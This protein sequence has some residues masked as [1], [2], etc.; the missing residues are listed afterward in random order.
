MSILP[1]HAHRTFAADERSVAK[2]RAFAREMLEAWDAGDLADSVVLLVSELVTNAV[3]HAGTTARLELRLDPQS[4]RVEVEDLHPRRVLPMVVAEP[5]E[6][7]EEGRGLLIT[8]SLASAWGVDYTSASKRVWLRFDR[9]VDQLSVPRWSPRPGDPRGHAHVAVAELSGDGVVTA[10]NDDAVA[11]F[12]WS[13]DEVRGR[14]FDELLDRVPGDHTTEAPSTAKMASGWQGTYCVLHKDADPVLVFASHVGRER[15]RGSTALMVATDQRVLIERPPV[16]PGQPPADPGILGLMDEALVRLR[17]DDYLMLAVERVRDRLSADAAYLLMLRDLEDEYEVKAVSGLSASMLGTR[18]ASNAA[19]T[20]D[21]R[22]PHLPVVVGDLAQTSVPLLAGTGLR[23]LVL[24]PISAESRVVGAIGVGSAHVEGFSTDQSV[25]L[26]QIANALAVATDRARLQSLER[27]R[28]G[29]LTFLAEA[30]DFLAGSLDQEMTMAITG[31]IVVPKIAQWCAVH[32]DDDRGHPVLEQVWHED[33][34]QTEPL[35][36]HLEK[37]PA[38][39][40]DE[41]G[42]V[43]AAVEPGIWGEVLTVPLVARGRRIGHLSLGRPAGDPLRGEPLLVAESVARRAA[44][45][46]ENARAHGE[47]KA[48]GNALQ[49]SLLPSSTPEAQGLDVGVVYEAAGQETTAGGDFYD[50]FPIGNGKSCFVVGDVCGTGPEAAAVTGLARHTIRALVLAGFPISDVLERL[51]TAI[52]DE[53]ERS[54]FLTLVCGIL[55]PDGDAMRVGMVSA[56]H[57]LPMIVRQTG[58]IEQVGRPQSLLGVVDDVRYFEEQYRLARGELFVAV[59]D[60]VLERRV[61]AVMIGEDGLATELGSIGTSLSAQAVAE[62][63]RRL[64]VEFA[65]ESPRDDMAV[66][67]LRVGEPVLVS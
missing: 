25:L 48:I 26:Q 19:G 3:V 8:F 16:R 14:P 59:T 53:G 10:W 51:N 31:Q 22:T 63:V 60:G 30:G 1:L 24:V 37:N 65:P 58:K 18:L 47:L 54:R 33:E 4:V 6:E 64:V 9:P 35:R 41:V 50:L 27:E 32:L 61:G 20:P 67:V 28:R 17:L 62:R 5:T 44:I 42:D 29:W 43:D 45:A 38:P 13:L 49:R 56:G 11:M 55:E 57:P 46:I 66:L 2:A 23:S 21:P 7:A 39:V 12:G 40:P 36:A 34:R 15:G 52:I